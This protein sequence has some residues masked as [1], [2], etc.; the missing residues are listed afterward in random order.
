MATAV[1]VVEPAVEAD[2]KSTKKIKL[3]KTPEYAVWAAMKQRCINRKHPA[4]KQ[5]GGRGIKVC[6]RWMQFKAFFADMGPR[7][8]ANYS[9]DRID[10]NR[11]YEPSNCRWTTF[12]V[13]MR[14]T[15]RAVYLTLGDR[16][17]RLADWA[18]EIGI[19][20]MTL[21]TRLETWTVE[22]ALTTP[23]QWKPPKRYAAIFA[24]AQLPGVDS[25]DVVAEAFVP[26]YVI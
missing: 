25:V 2:K 15:R 13:Q 14:N 11:G 7:P 20:P 10:N 12:D 4:Y 16:T 6:K 23:S 8:D 9:L 19:S 21:K 18:A 3:S 22:R 17:M 26:N 1:A 5:Y 24:E